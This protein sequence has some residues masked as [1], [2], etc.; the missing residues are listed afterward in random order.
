MGKLKEIR[1]FARTT[2]D[3]LPGIRADLA[4]LDDN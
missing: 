4:R 3:K 2:L 1:G